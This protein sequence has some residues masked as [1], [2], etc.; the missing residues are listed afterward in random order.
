MLDKSL[1]CIMDISSLN[2]S[3]TVFLRYE[4]LY[5]LYYPATH[6]ETDAQINYATF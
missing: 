2:F 3:N 1:N 6:E 5:I 4:L